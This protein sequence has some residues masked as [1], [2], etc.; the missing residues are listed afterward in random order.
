MSDRAV[1]ALAVVAAIGARVARPVPLVLAAASL[2]VAF[3]ARVGPAAVA[4]SSRCRPSCVGPERP[5]LAWAGRPRHRPCR[6]TGDAGLRSGADRAGCRG[7]PAP[8]RRSLPGR[9]LRLD[10]RPASDSEPQERRSSSGAA[11]ARPLRRHGLARPPPHRRR[12]RGRLRG[13]VVTRRRPDPPG[14]PAPPHARSRRRGDVPGASGACSAASCSVTIA[15]RARQ[16]VDDFRA[17]RVEPSAGR[18]RPERR[19]GSGRGVA[20]AAPVGPGRPVRGDRLRHRVLRPHDPVRAV[21]AACR[22]R[23]PDSPPWPPPSAG[24]HRGCGCSRW[25]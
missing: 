16:I 12:A 4:P 23:W 15:A 8:G 17:V 6:R 24:R 21:G 20:R 11:P 25:P 13:P 3:G 7:R 2:A 9:R 18:V 22:R 19:L 1:V 14:Q 5:R 10:G